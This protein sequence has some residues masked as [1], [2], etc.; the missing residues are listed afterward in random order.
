MALV[1]STHLKTPEERN[2][3]IF[4][5]TAIAALVVLSAGCASIDPREAALG[6][7][8]TAATTPAQHLEV[9]SAY[10]RLAKEEQ[11]AARWHRDWAAEQRDRAGYFTQGRPTRWGPSTMRQHCELSETA[12]ARA[13]VEYAAQAERH[14]RMAE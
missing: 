3:M 13:A 12:H 6:S 9:A 4:R 7:Q 14:R 8:A 11:G 10:D 5:T 1:P 2:H